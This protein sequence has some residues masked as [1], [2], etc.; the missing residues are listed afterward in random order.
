VAIDFITGEKFSS[1][2]NH[3]KLE[4]YRSINEINVATK[5]NS[6]KALP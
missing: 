5:A 4:D 3:V 2:R 1:D 6:I